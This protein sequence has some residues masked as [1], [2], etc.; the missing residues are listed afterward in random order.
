M[1]LASMNKTLRPRKGAANVQEEMTT[2]SNFD[3][4]S[5]LVKILGDKIDKLGNDN[6][7]GFMKKLIMNHKANEKCL[8]FQ[9]NISP[10]IPDFCY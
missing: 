5:R 7:L 3:E 1:F 2:D 8:E 6:V 9:M 4:L 10:N